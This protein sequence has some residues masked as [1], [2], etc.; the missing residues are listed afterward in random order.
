MAMCMCFIST[1]VLGWVFWLPYQN[2]SRMSPNKN[3]NLLTHVTGNSRDS[4]ALV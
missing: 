4:A 2:P 3:V 1:I